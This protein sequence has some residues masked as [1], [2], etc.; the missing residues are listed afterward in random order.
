MIDLDDP[1]RCPMDSSCIGC[2]GI[3][4]LNVRTLDSPVGVFCVTLCTTCVEQGDLPNFAVASA[5]RA[6]L[7][8]CEH[9]GIDVDQMAAAM[10]AE[11]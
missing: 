4:D 1:S 10:E 7:E 11:Q 8:H 2:R 5:A 9:L 3:W 6:A